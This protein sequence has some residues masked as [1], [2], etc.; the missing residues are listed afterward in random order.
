MCGYIK[1]LQGSCLFCC[2]S[3]IKA[4][5]R[6]AYGRPRKAL[7]QDQINCFL[8][9]SVPNCR[10]QPIATWEF[11]GEGVGAPCHP[12]WIGLSLLINRYLPV[13]ALIDVIEVVVVV[14]PVW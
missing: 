10:R 13:T 5:H 9:G 11:Q 12:F 4:F 6:V 3:A 1:F 8:R 14:Q 7:G 2:F